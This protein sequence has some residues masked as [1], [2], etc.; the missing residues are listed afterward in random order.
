MR[1]LKKVLVYLGVH[2]FL[3]IRKIPEYITDFFKFNR[4][5]HTVGIDKKFTAKFNNIY[6]IFLDK[7]ATHGFDRHYIFHTAW[8]AR[9]V[10]KINPEFLVDIS[11]SLYFS[12]I[13]SAFVPVKFYDYRPADLSL[14]GLIS[15]Q[16]DLMRLPIDDNSL[17]C[18]SC[19]H[20]IEHVGLGRYGDPIDPN[21]DFTAIQELI[22]VTKPGGNIIYVTPVGKSAVKFNAHRIYSFEQIL[23][24][25]SGCEIEEFSLIQD[26]EIGGPIILNADP[27]LVSKQSYACGLFHFIKK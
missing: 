24:R 18:I 14:S 27:I 16:G 3:S 5:S 10:K 11:S 8:A 15:K 13:I 21:A 19:M 26:D 7:T 17:D 6:P 2:K 25:F 23:E 4:L 12:T 20:V 1:K 22:R 9:I